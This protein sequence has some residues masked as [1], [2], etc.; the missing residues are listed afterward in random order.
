MRPQNG[1][2]DAPAA[3]A[4]RIPR[5]ERFPGQL[6]RKHTLPRGDAPAR[7]ERESH[8]APGSQPGDRALAPAPPR[9]RLAY[10]ARRIASASGRCSSSSPSAQPALRFTNGSSDT[11][12]FQSNS[13]RQTAAIAYRPCASSREGATMVN[14]LRVKRRAVEEGR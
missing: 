10:L 8:T 1:E 9:E 14:D 6:E 12:S 2:R 11:P 7:D 3:R 5:T 13:S 4:D